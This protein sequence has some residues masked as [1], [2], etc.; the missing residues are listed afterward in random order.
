[1]Y[2]GKE[3]LKGRYVRHSRFPYPNGFWSILRPNRGAVGNPKGGC[4]C[5]L[6]THIQSILL[7]IGSDRSNRRLKVRW[8]RKRK[9]ERGYALCLDSH[10]SVSPCDEFFQSAPPK[11]EEKRCVVKER[12]RGFVC[13]SDIY[14]IQF[15]WSLVLIGQTEGW[16]RNFE[17]GY[18]RHLEFIPQST[19]AINSSDRLDGWVV[20]R[21][22]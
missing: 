5:H 14:F 13:H 17:G 2:S 22:L 7:V 9:P 20:R 21:M 8:A 16:K 10:I 3:P 1:M 18:A 19:P 4:V 11:W 12:Q 15:L 6:D